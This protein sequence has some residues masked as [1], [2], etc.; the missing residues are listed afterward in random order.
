MPGREHRLDDEGRR[1]IM[2]AVDRDAA[3]ALLADTVRIPSVTGE[4]SAVAR[5]IAGELAAA[6]AAT[7]VEDFLPGRANAWGVLRGA[8]GGRGLM[9][10]AHLDTVHARGWAERWKGDPRENP[11]GAAVVDGELWGRGAA[12]CKA[13][14]CAAVAALQTLRRAG[15]R[16]LG[17]VTALFIGDEESGEPGTGLSAGM[18]SAMGRL[19]SGAIPRPDFAVY[20]EP[21][22]LQLLT[23][24]I[25]FFIAEIRLEGRSSY[26]GAPELGVDALRAGHRVLD[27]LWRYDEA[28][29]RRPAHPLL[30]RPSLLVTGM[31]SGGFVAVP[32]ECTLTLIR[33]LLPGESLDEAR[34]ELDRVVAEAG[35]DPEVRV[36]VD[37][38]APRDHAVGGTPAETD[39]AEDGVLRLRD[40]VLRVRPDRGELQGAPF[41]SEIPFLTTLG[42]PAVYFAPGDIRECHTFNERLPLDEYLDGVGILATFIADYCGVTELASGSSE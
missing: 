6:G 34:A 27:A 19:A 2:E 15:L 7:R 41:W 36:S 9:L 24:Q 22:R 35:T 33:K 37:Y 28:L 40:A 21:T 10:L 25:G 4:E 11:F 39:P 23:A 12:D 5:F 13:G 8:G 38:T 3:V 30:G 1:R 17:D 31:V 42:I 26:F 16:P 29:A 32:G 18:K 14:V 20:G